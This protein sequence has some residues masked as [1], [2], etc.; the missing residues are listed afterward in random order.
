MQIGM[1]GLGKMGANMAL[2]LM[3]GGHACAG[4]DVDPVKVS[5]LKEAGAT[6]AS[7]VEEFV[8]LLS[9]PRVAWVMVPAGAPTEQ[10]VMSLA[11]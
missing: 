5:A 10:M 6:G 4:L 8:A 2:R 1:V 7:N 9:K 11:A 3:K